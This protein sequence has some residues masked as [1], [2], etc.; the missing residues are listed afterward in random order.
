[1]DTQ[2]TATYD[3]EANA[4]AIKVGSGRKAARADQLDDRL[5][6]AVSASGKPI[7]VALLYPDLG[8][9]KPLLKAAEAYELDVDTLDLVARSA[10]AGPGEAVTAELLSG[11]FVVRVPKSLHAKLARQAEVNGVSLNQFVA[12][13]LAG[14]AA[15][16]ESTG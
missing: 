13:A 10:I 5:I 8:I 12:T 16:Q 7:E 2:Y 4:L 15:R 3:P 9:V 1:M 6:V 11:K 14:E